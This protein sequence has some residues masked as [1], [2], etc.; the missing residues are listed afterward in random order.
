VLTRFLAGHTV[1]RKLDGVIR[2]TGFV[3]YPTVVPPL[4]NRHQ[5]LVPHWNRKLIGKIY[6]FRIDEQKST[7]TGIRN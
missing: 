7:V 4:W 2:G 3:G 6:F 5:A 1:G